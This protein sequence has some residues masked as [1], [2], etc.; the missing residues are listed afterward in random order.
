MLKWTS[1]T[2]FIQMVYEEV[3]WKW[4]SCPSFCIIKA[5]YKLTCLQHKV[6]LQADG[7]WS[8]VGYVIECTQ[9]TS[10]DN[11]SPEGLTPG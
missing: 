7:C 11:R 10:D 3:W 5:Q 9:E 6:M 1:Q 8:A 4:M 2:Q